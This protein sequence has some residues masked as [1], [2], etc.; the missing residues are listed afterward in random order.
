MH[1]CWK[2][3]R[4]TLVSQS[5]SP[6]ALNLLA[7][8]KGWLLQ[9][10]LSEPVWR[11][12][13]RRFSSLSSAL[14]VCI[15][16]KAGTLS[17]L[18]SV[19][20]YWQALLDGRAASSRTQNRACTRLVPSQA[21]RCAIIVD[22]ISFPPTPVPSVLCL[23]LNCMHENMVCSSLPGESAYSQDMQTE[24]AVTS[25]GSR[26]RYDSD[27]RLASSLRSRVWCMEGSSSCQTLF[28][29]DAARL[30]RPDS[31]GLQHMLILWS[32]GGL[33]VEEKLLAARQHLHQASPRGVVLLVLLQMDCQ[34]GDPRGQPGD[35]D[36]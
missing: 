35:L 34:L 18:Y 3:L 28:S 11:A 12:A 32:V 15:Y 29:S 21:S 26:E 20:M 30:G 10:L 13:T 17:P 31:Q 8:W 2:G 19:C 24:D 16:C 33:Q 9:M 25:A 22:H 1:C 36:L 4:P 6:Q 5:L 7:G 23:A 14:S 27:L